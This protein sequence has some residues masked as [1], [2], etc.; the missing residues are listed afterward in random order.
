[1]IVGDDVGEDDGPE[2]GLQVYVVVGDPVK[3]KPVDGNPVDAVGEGVIGPTGSGLFSPREY[4]AK[5]LT[6]P[7]GRP[8]QNNINEGE[9]EVQSIRRGKEQV[10]H[11][12]MISWNM[13][14]ETR[15]GWLRAEVRVEETEGSSIFSYHEKLLHDFDRNFL[16]VAGGDGGGER[17]L[18]QLEEPPPLH[19]YGQAPG[20]FK[21]NSS[22]SPKPHEH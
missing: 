15:R 8:W 9:R 16:E 18:P 14:E 10:W 2:V 3:G 6:P 7:V 5:A 12:Y 1:M 13:I 20:P 22:S 21:V 17:V 4:K 19:S 11:T